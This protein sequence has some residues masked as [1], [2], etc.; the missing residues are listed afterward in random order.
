M[1]ARVVASGLGTLDDI[2]VAPNGT[3]YIGDEP[4]GRVSAWSP[5]TGQLRLIT[6][7]LSHPEGIVALD[8]LLVVC[9]QGKN[10]L[11][12]VDPSNGS[13][14]LFRALS[15][16]TRNL[17]V[18]GLALDTVEPSIVV[19]DSPNGTLL[20]ISLDGGTATPI[21]VAGT[22]QPP[23]ARPTGAFALS[24]RSLLVADE[25]G[26]DIALLRADGTLQILVTGLDQPDDVLGDDRGNVYV[27]SVGDGVLHRFQGTAH[28]KLVTGLG[29]PHGLAFDLDG[30][31]LVT[32]LGA[33]GRLIKV[34]VR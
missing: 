24:D 5:A 11:S 22:R 13:V 32:D 8:S 25:D 18:D 33:G 17:G 23:F 7:A 4:G 12:R 26:G 3:V 6:D 20:R 2:A 16:R 15:N 27:N 1:S 9:E 21:V 28:V 14:T 30:N 34:F 10:Q 29:A 31:L 19:P